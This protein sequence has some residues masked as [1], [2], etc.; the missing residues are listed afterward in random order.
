MSHDDYM[1]QITI[2]LP[3]DLHDWIKAHAEKE[4]R[5][6]NAEILWLMEQ[7]WPIYQ[8]QKLKKRKGKL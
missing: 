5:S 7:S 3:D 6:I 1:G 2:R 4:H 8:D